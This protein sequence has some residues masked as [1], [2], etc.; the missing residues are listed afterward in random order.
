M[1]KPKVP[2]AQNVYGK[3][4]YWFSITA[5][6]ICTIG[7]VITV[8]F[9]NNNLMDPHY[10]FPTIWEGNDPEAVWQEVGEGFPGGHFWMNNLTTGDGFTQLGLEIGCFCSALGL[11][12]A[13]IAYLCGK[14]RSYGWAVISLWIVMLVILSVLG[15]FGL[16]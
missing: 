14:P 5:A 4:V 13:A 15:I 3:L 7:S 9:P 16:K 8:A 1:K 6:I 12:G 11:M 10:L 2:R